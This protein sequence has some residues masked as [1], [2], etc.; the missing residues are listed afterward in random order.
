MP[1]L[2]RKIFPMF[3]DRGLLRGSRTSCSLFVAR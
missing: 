3:V 1:W 2:V